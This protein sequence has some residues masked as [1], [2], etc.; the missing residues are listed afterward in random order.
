[1][2]QNEGT[3]DRIVRVVVGVAALA[4]GFVVGIS[5]GGGI[6]LAA[7]GA[8]ALVTGATGFCPLYRLFGLSTRP[9]SKADTGA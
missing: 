9:A 8:I 5:T 3:T 7:V 6:A 4:G 2:A 1:M